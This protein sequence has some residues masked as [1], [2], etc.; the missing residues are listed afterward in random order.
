MRFYSAEYLKQARLLCDSFEVLLIVDEI[1]TGFGRTGE[2]F[3]VHHADV[4]PDIMCVGKALTGGY[5][6]MGATMTSEKVAQGI[7][8]QGGVFMHGPTFMANPLACSVALASLDVLTQS[9]WQVRVKEIQGLLES[10]LQPLQGQ[11]HDVRV[12]GAI[13]V[14]ELAAP[15][16]GDHMVRV[17][18]AFVDK[19][20]WMRPFGRLVYTMPPFGV[21]SDE[22]VGRVTQAIVDVVQEECL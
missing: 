1:A 12:M 3:G 15:L 9:N 11:V 18:R 19:G 14:C 16:Q 4:N 20:V 17:Q 10:G 5:M 21:V 2:M 22:Q 13:G 6:T 7:S 8:S